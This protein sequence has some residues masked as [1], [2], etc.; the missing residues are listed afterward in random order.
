MRPPVWAVAAL[1][2]AMPL[3]MAGQGVDPLAWR[4]DSSVHSSFPQVAMRHAEALELHDY[5]L[6]FDALLRDLEASPEWSGD[7]REYRALHRSLSTI[8]E[9]FAAFDAELAQTG[10]VAG[11]V[12]RFLATVP[13]GLFQE[14]DQGWFSG[15][16]RVTFEDVEA[17]PQAKAQDFLHRRQ[18]VELLLTRFRR[19]SRSRALTAIRQ[20]ADRWE[21]FLD[22]GRSQ[23]PWETWLNEHGPLRVA[24]SI[25]RPP[26]R[27]W[28][29][30]HPELGVEVRTSGR[31]LSEGTA[32]E[33]ALLHL[34][35]H[36]WY[37][38]KDPMIPSNG[39]RWW[40]LSTA[41]TLQDATGPGFGIVAMYGP[42]ITVG[43]MWHDEDRPGSWL[44]QPPRLVFGIDLYR[45]ATQDRPAVVGELDRRKALV[46]AI[47]SL[48]ER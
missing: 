46:M 4:P 45:F 6:V 19:P 48:A 9:R 11:A 14:V 30:A 2:A 7:E 22:R 1:L 37:R 41:A 23:Y 31:W 27:Q 34:I 38:W 13:T 39:L 42:T 12:D 47:D 40:G 16:D 26:E 36:V 10:D 17:L 24:S 5:R 21:V 8:A 32:S 28:V 3:P 35:G 29:V 25:Q 20:A 15:G 18:A 33:A 43:A 44:S